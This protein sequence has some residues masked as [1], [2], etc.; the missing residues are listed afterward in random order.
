MRSATLAASGL[1]LALALTFGGDARAQPSGTLEHPGTCIVVEVPGLL[2]LPDGSRP[3][4]IEIRLCLVRWYTPVLALHE[5]QADGRSLGLLISR[6]G[7]DRQ[8]VEHDP[9][10]VFDRDARRNAR[11]VGYAFPDLGRL[12]THVFVDW[13]GRPS[14]G[15]LDPDR[16]LAACEPGG[17]LVAIRSS[18]R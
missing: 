13:P 2:E 15:S 7:I 8:S 12:T 6:V 3:E 1:G 4:A 11:L 5:L 10:V 18:G 14:P 17:S 9:V 16:L